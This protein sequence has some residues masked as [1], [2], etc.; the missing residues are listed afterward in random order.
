MTLKAY[1]ITLPDSPKAVKGYTRC[2][3][4]AEKFGYQ[5]E[6]FHGVKWEDAMGFIKK[7]NMPINF[8][9]PHFFD[10]PD[11]ISRVIGC[12]ASH[13]LLWEKVREIDEPVVILEHDAFFV[14][15]ISAEVVEKTVYLCNLGRPVKHRIDAMYQNSV[16]KV[17]QFSKGLHLIRYMYLMGAH[18]YLITP[19]GAEILLKSADLYGMKHVDRFISAAYLPEFHD[20]APWPVH[21]DSKYRVLKSTSQYGYIL[22]RIVNKLK[23]ITLGVIGKTP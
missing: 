11:K 23:R 4:S 16:R 12:F 7:R 22:R 2:I 17:E 8:I 6:P 13:L 14:A 10:T 20:F 18:A 1:C 21:T 15:P 9:D 19:A 3:K 5:V